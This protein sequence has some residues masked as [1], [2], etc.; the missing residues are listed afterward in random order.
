MVFFFLYGYG[1][2]G[3]SYI[4]KTVSSYIR[5]KG[6]IVV[7]VALSGIASLLLTGSMTTHSRFRIPINL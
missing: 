1:G 4:W 6:E 3:K 2:M 5:S 7:N